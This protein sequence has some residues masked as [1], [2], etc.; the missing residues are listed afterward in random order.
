MSTVIAVIFGACPHLLPNGAREKACAPKHLRAGKLL[1]RALP[2]YAALNLRAL[3]PH[4]E[5]R[6]A[7]KVGSYGDGKQFPHP[8]SRGSSHPVSRIFRARYG[9]WNRVGRAP[10]AGVFRAVDDSSRGDRKS[11]V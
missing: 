5:A 4:P 10:S 1:R 9:L 2:H 6:P 3:R 11:V 7:P 8:I